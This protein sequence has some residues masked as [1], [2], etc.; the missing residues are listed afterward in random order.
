MYRISIRVE[1]EEYRKDLLVDALAE[2]GF[3]AFED[4]DFGLAAYY[5]DSSFDESLLATILPSE[6]KYRVEQLDDN[7]WQ[8]FI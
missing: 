2:A 4:N 3:E 1:L 7:L 8:R 5:P 6:A